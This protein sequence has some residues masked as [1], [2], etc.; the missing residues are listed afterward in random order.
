MILTDT[1][2]LVVYERKPTA[3][4]RKIIANEDAAVCGLAAAEMFAGVVTAKDAVKVRKALTDFRAMAV[5]ESLW[6]QAGLKQATLRTNGV[7]VP[8]IDTMLATLSISLGV[9]LWAYDR[10]F[11]DIQ[12]VLPS[13]QLFQEPP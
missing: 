12:P 1:T 13:L 11:G 5:P 7:T 4:L 10:H 3:R 9:A 8:L 6:E 2:V